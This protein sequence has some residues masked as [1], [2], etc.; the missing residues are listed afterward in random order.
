MDWLEQHRTPITALL[1]VLI[2]IGGAVLLYRQVASPHSTGIVISTPSPEICV[3][4][5]GA[6]TNPGVYILQDGDRAI[7]AI[8]AA[9]G[10]TTD[11]DQS[12]VNLAT[13]LRNSDHIHIYRIGDVPQKININTA[14]AWL[15]EALNGIGPSLAQRIVDYR[16]D[17]GGFQRIEDLKHVDGIGT[18]T[19]EKL[20]DKIT[21]H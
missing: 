18:T 2:L 21:V 8:E 12:T 1:V 3:Y 20:K 6:V 17:N 16:D 9:G 14:D 11:A 5:E 13:P 10:F 19:F 7:A 4:V 15:L